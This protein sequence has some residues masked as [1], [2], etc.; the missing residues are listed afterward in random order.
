[1]MPRTLILLLASALA[2][3]ST[4]AG[5]VMH[6]SRDRFNETA[7]LTN[8]EQLLRNLVRLRYAE[9]PYFLEISSVSTSATM[10]GSLGIFGNTSP[11][12]P[13]LDPNILINPTV[14]YSQTPSFVFQPLTGEKFG[15]QLL[16]P[17]ELRTIALL[18]TAG[19]DLRDILLVLVDSINGVANAPTATQFAPLTVPENAEF[20][21]VVEI[22]DRLEDSGLIQLG[23]E[24]N[25]TD[26]R[27]DI[28]L[29]VRIEKSVAGREDVQELTRRLALDPNNLTY[30]LAAAA[31]GG[32]GQTIVIKPRSVLAAMRY[33]SKGI[34]VPEADRRDGLVPVGRDAAGAPVDWYRMLEGVFTVRTSDTMPSAAYVSVRHDGHWFHIDRTDLGTKQVFALLETVFALQGGDVPPISTVLTLPIAR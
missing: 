19:W 5:N 26:P 21:R 29:S 10:A 30:R 28:V 9:S 18:R 27:G 13:G 20:R 24:A 14:S 12:I 4:I 1:M 34:V 7:Q 22:I 8:A 32:G 2:G 11:A 16:R 3:C 25:A 15:R 6:D 17:V 23:L 31:T 33:L